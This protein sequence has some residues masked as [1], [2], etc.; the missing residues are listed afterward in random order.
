MTK[1]LVIDDDNGIVEALQIALELSGFEVGIRQDV[2]EIDEYINSFKPD[3]ILLDLLL[4]GSDGLAVIKTI[5][6]DPR[7]SKIPIILTSAHPTASQLVVGSGADDFISKPFDLDHLIS[8]LNSIIRPLPDNL[9][10]A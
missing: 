2:V 7:I 8:I 10:S 4:S 9:S 1:I 5:R 6:N 3:C